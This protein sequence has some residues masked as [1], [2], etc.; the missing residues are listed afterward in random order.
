[1]RDDEPGP[2]WF[3]A[4]LFIGAVAAVVLWSLALVLWEVL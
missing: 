4:M 3:M 2:G 1:M